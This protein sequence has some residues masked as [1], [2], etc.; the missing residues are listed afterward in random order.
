MGKGAIVLALI[1]IIIGAGGLIFGFI[2]WNSM[3]TMEKTIGN[4]EDTI[5]LLQDELED[6]ENMTYSSP[7]K[8]WYS[9]YEDV[10]TISPATTVLELSVLNVTFE[11]NS[12]SSIYLSFTG[13]AEVY[14]ISGYSR[15]F[16]FFK[17]DGENILN[18]KSVVGSLN[19]GSQRDY[20]SVNLQHFI[21]NMVAGSHNVTLSVSSTNA[22]NTVSDMTL[23]V[24]S[25]TP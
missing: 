17:V 7:N 24:Q 9:E 20:F 5:T 25:F 2:A 18:P 1:G 13:V 3:N 11:L 10:F 15:S 12:S 22:L 16:F 21:N 19:G 8:T 6:L 23:F 4:F 14:P